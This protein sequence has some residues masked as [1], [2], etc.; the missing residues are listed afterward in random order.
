MMKR[1]H[2]PA[3]SSFT[4]NRSLSGYHAI[5]QAPR[6]CARMMPQVGM[7]ATPAR[8]HGCDFLVYDF[9]FGSNHSCKLQDEPP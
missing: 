8:T 5:C 6:H 9:F 7:F 4:S 2:S 3:V 1:A